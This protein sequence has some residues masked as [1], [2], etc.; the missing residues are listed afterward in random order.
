MLCYVMLCYV[1]MHNITL[2][3]LVW[4]DAELI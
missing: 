4:F 3:E 2:A 1:N